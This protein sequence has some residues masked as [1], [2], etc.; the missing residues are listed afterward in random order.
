ME[1]YGIGICYISEQLFSRALLSFET[2]CIMFNYHW[3]RITK[4]EH[5]VI[6]SWVIEMVPLTF[7]S[8]IS[9]VDGCRNHLKIFFLLVII[10]LDVIRKT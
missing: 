1:Y 10:I 6:V 2:I 3:K 4:A 8:L 9:S 5:V 7:P